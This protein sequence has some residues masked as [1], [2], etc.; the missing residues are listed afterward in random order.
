[1]APYSGER[2]HELL[3]AQAHV[4]NH[5]YHYVNSMSLKCAVELGIPDI[6]HNHGRP[7]TLSE[8]VAALKIN[9]SKTP[10]MSRLMRLLV[11]LGFFD[12]EKINGN[13][14]VEEGYVITPP[15]SLLRK[16]ATVSLSA[17]V[18]EEL[19]SSLLTNWNFLSSWFQG[20][21]TT[22]FE[23]ANGLSFLEVAAEIPEINCLFND[24]MAS[25]AQF[26]I[27]IVVK[28]YGQVFDGLR[29]LVDVGGGTGAVARAI[30][31]AF[32]HVKCTVFDQP[33]VI[34]HVPKSTKIDVVGGNMFESIPP[35]DALLL[36]SVLHG[37]SDNDCVKILKRCKEVIPTKEDGGKVILLE[38][39]VNGD[40]D[41]YKSMET[42]LCFDV[43]MM[44]ASTGKEREEHVWQKI[45]I[46]AGFSDYKI[47]PVLG[48][49]SIIE[50]YP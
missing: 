37:W 26:I 17:F 44:L 45:F 2:G 30:A 50:V 49:R 31:D 33:H 10:Y 46:D 23:K 12:V 11:H 43:M 18:L 27:S 1:M 28:E 5:L 41:D 47:L 38:T 25:D 32:P 35:A 20:N 3:Q 42:K 48:L 36:K 15:S 34:A 16:E 9:S 40:T 4:W 8:L 14:G 39:V 6:I 21:E 7:M 24:S 19:D 13:N 29:S 22:A